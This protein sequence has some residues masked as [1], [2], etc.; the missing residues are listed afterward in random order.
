MIR[1][2]TTVYVEVPIKRPR[3][4]QTCDVAYPKTNYCP[5]CGE[6]LVSVRERLELKIEK[7]KK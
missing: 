1:T 5:Q 3:Y 2:A 4:C 7:E 6:P